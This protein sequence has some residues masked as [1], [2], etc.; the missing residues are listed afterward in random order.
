MTKRIA[1]GGFLHESHS[2]APRPTTYGISCSPAAFPAC[3]WQRR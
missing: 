1:I 3:P 2:F